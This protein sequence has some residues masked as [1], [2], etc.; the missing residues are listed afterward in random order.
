MSQLPMP[1]FA[2]ARSSFWIVLLV[3]AN[4]FPMASALASG[5]EP[6][7]P[8]DRH[9]QRGSAH[10]RATKL[11]ANTNK[12]PDEG[13]A[14][15]TSD[16][17]DMLRCGLDL[18][19]DPTAG[20]VNG[21][22]KMVL[23]SLEA[24]L[25]TVVFDLSSA[26][27]VLSISH[28]TGNLPYT[29]NGDSVV[30]TL[31][32][33]LAMDQLDSLVISYRGTETEPVFDRG[34]MF[35]EFNLGGVDG[36]SVANLSQPAYAKYWWPCKDK[37]GDKFLASVNVTVPDDLVAV[38]NGT[39][40]GTSLPEAG[41]KT[42]FWQEDYP[43]ASYLVSVAVGDY[44]ELID[45][46]STSQ[47]SEIPIS[48]WVFPPDE[49]DALVDFEPLCEMMEM[50]EGFFGPYPF[51]GEKYGHAEFLWSGAMEH[52][53]VTSIGY[54]SL[55]GDRS[56]D[57]LVVHEL[58]H[59]WFGDSLTPDTWADIWLNE[60]FATYCESLWEE[61]LSGPQAYLDNLLYWR[62]PGIWS[63]QGP[64]FDPSPVFPGRVIYDKGA[65]ILHML[66]R[67][68]G[69]EV[70][71]PMIEA[72]S[73][74]EDRILETV[75]TEEFISHVNTW[76]DQDLGAF[77]WPYLNETIIPQIDFDFSL[78]EGMFGPGSQVNVSI[79][80]TQ[81][82]LFDNIFPVVVTTASGD[83]THLVPLNTAQN[84]VVLEADGAITN[85]QLD[86]HSWV[87]WETTGVA[88]P[89]EG[90]VAA[91]PNPSVDGYVQLKYRLDS[92]SNVTLEIY[93]LRG[94]LVDRQNLGL[95]T[96]DVSGNEVVWDE[97][98]QQ[99]Q[100]VAAGTYWARLDIGGRYSVIKFTVLR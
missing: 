15:A 5:P 56:H 57:W 76:S 87:L 77:F 9:D 62:R 99:G 93:N 37:P 71:F 4:I 33:A 7:S 12:G 58:G 21:S 91:Y 43:I 73:Q 8:H 50:C 25:G 53:T 34:L 29:H 16:R 18:R 55:I 2:R 61:E 79:S 17:Y 49:D 60:G 39:F 19:L 23:T 90:L 96:P 89:S 32:V 1:V 86:P 81:N 22:V 20:S 41:W 78:A 52:Q 38:S 48:N 64:V 46:C 100:P 97:L 3:L 67:R 24:D 35:R 68:L 27:E 98:D 14:A 70:F 74:G 6:S 36:I 44:V 54:G 94:A 40:L 30:V 13:D 72:W 45:H 63:R 47:G 75:T 65:W 83:S 92:P 88:G 69:D 95:V 26:M 11:S 42:Y 31:P 82:V 84:T 51:A 10:Y 85:I 59:Q 28:L 80:Q 66:R